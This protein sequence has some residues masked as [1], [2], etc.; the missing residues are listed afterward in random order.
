MCDL[1]HIIL[2]LTKYPYW[3]YSIERSLMLTV[4]EHSYFIRKAEKILTQ[5]QRI[6]LIDFIS[7]RYDQGDIM[8]GT[9]GVRKV[10][11]AHQ[12]GKGKSG[13]SRVIYLVVDELGYVHLLDIFEKNVKDNLSKAERN[14]IRKL[15]EILKKRKRT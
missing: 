13:A 14:E 1:L 12:T 3:V 5:E 11:F 2:L 7:I 4:I 8:A 6:E 15:I 10:R 9:G